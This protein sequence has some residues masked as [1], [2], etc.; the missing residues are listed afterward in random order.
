MRQSIAGATGVRSFGRNSGGGD[1]Q[2]S[3]VGNGAGGQECATVEVFKAGVTVAEKL[4]VASPNTRNA[5]EINFFMVE[6]PFVP[7]EFF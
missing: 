6:V 4:T 3:L 7:T 1:Q 2:P 5:A